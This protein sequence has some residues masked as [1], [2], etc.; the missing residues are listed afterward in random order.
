MTADFEPDQADLVY[1]AGICALW[2]GYI[3]ARGATASPTL[4][5]APVD[6]DEPATRWIAQAPENARMLRQL[7]DDAGL[8]VS[9]PETN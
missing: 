2:L 5:P 7:L 8:P 3:V 6:D 1:I 9:H 4:P